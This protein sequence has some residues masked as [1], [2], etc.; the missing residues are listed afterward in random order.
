MEIKSPLTFY[1]FLLAG[2]NQ[3]TCGPDLQ[4][5]VIVHPL[6]PTFVSLNLSNQEEAAC[7]NSEASKLGI[8]S[9]VY[10]L[11]GRESN[12]HARASLKAKSHIGKIKTKVGCPRKGNQRLPDS[13]T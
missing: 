1:S 11:C 8:R 6:K 9:D 4:N 2:V 3:R 13:L 10:L 7:Q 12:G 5:S